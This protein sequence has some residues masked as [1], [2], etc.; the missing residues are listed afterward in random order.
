MFENFN[1]IGPDILG[2]LILVSILA[3]LYWTAWQR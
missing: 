1:A 3:A 2:L